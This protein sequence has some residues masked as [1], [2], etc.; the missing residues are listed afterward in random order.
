MNWIFKQRFP[1]TYNVILL[2]HLKHINLLEL[3]LIK[4]LDNNTKSYCICFK[5][6]F[7]LQSNNKHLKEV[8]HGKNNC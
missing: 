6:T 8:S 2:I 1:L 4:W 3:T 7:T 5:Q